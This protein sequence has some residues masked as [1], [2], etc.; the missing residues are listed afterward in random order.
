VNHP[1]VARRTPT[2]C[3]RGHACQLRRH[4]R[5]FAGNGISHSR[6]TRRRGRGHTEV[7]RAQASVN[8]KAIRSRCHPNYTANKSPTLALP[9]HRA[10]GRGRGS[11]AL[12]VG[13]AA[14]LRTCGTFPHRDG[15]FAA[16]CEDHLLAFFETLRN[17]TLENGEE[18]EKA[19][20]GD[21]TLVRGCN[22]P[23]LPLHVCGCALCQR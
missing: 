16:A 17:L 11:S 10:L 12:R 3:G 2:L 15:S 9:K 14:G 6:R 7:L 22:V 18:G 21:S 20:P 13:A 23:G 4:T 8:G 1:R 19:K 5:G